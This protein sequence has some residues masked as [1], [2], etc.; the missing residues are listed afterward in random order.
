MKL[1][2]HHLLDIQVILNM[3]KET[4]ASKGLSMLHSHRGKWGKVGL[5][6]YS[7]KKKGPVQMMH[8]LQVQ[9]KSVLVMKKNSHIQVKTTISSLTLVIKITDLKFKYNK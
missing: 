5:S 6:K 8:F 4:S 2:V 1:S 7:A 9:I 3:D